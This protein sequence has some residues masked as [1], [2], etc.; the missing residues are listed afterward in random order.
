MLMCFY[1]LGARYAVWLWCSQCKQEMVA[2]I[3]AMRSWQHC[4]ALQITPVLGLVRKLCK[5]MQQQEEEQEAAAAQ[6]AAG[7]TQQHHR[8]TLTVYMVYSARSWSE[9][10]LLGADILS[11]A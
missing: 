11:A 10:Q 1:K 7:G 5:M 4:D 6:H 8:P 9:L 3:I 2:G